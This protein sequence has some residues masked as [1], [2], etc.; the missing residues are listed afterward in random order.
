MSLTLNK[1]NE[2]PVYEIT[3]LDYNRTTQESTLHVLLRLPTEENPIETT[4]KMP[5]TTIEP[6]QKYTKPLY[7]FR[8]NTSVFLNK[9][10]FERVQIIGQLRCMGLDTRFAT[11]CEYDNWIYEAALIDNDFKTHTGYTVWATIKEYVENL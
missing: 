1:F 10:L 9:G 6:W 11:Q 2:P 5:F 3:K 8:D 7:T 4:I